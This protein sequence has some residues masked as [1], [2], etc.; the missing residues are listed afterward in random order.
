MSIAMTGLSETRNELPESGVLGNFICPGPQT[1]TPPKRSTDG[2]SG[3]IIGETQAWHSHSIQRESLSWTKSLPV[4]LK[5]AHQ[6]KRRPVKRMCVSGCVRNRFR[7]LLELR[8]ALFPG[9]F[10]TNSRPAQ[11]R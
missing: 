11:Q 8:P 5:V 9:I 4:L 7:L 3:T 10:R 6:N 2:V 1:E